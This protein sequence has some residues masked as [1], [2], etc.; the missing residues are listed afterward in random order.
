MEGADLL[1]IRAEQYERFAAVALKR[2]EDDA[3]QWVRESW[4]EEFDAKG[5]EAVRAEVQG[6]VGRCRN[7]G[8][9]RGEHVLR[10]LNLCYAL[11]PD[12]DTAYAWAKGPLEHAAADPAGALDELEQGAEAELDAGEE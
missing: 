2:F 11:G 6:V 12:F 7:H 1:K 9:E 5:E 8:I 3:V 10:F 4:P